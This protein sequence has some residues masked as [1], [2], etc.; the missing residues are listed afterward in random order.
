MV[1][2]PPALQVAVVE[3]GAGVGLSGSN[4]N[5][6]SARTEVNRRGIGR[7]PAKPRSNIPIAQ[8]TI[9]VVTPA[10]QV[11]VVKDGAGVPRPSRNGNGCS[12]G[13]EVD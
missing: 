8:L 5:G 3:D 10:L 6:R 12:A 13:A 11:T 7:V 1:T 2:F 4:R 9:C